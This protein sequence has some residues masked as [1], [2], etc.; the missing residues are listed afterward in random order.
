[1]TGETM[2]D[3]VKRIVVLGST[4][5]VG[6]QTL[7]VV[8]SL[9]ERFCVVGLSGH[10]RCKLLA[11]QVKE[12]RPDIVA[13][14]DPDGVDS[15]CGAVDGVQVVC[16]AE[17]LTRLAAWEDADIIVCAV[18]GVAGVP[19]TV[20][21][22]RSGKVLALANKESVVMCGDYLNKLARENGGAIL[23]VDSE[24]SAVFQLLQGLPRDSV[25]RV[26]ITAS[27]GPFYDR[28]PAELEAVTPEEAV[29]HPNWNM[30]R[31]ISVDSATM[32]NKAL[33]VVEARWLFDLAPDRIDVLIHPQS[34]VHGIVELVDG[35]SLAHMGVPDMRIPIHYA[36][37]YPK[38]AA[39]G[40][41]RL[42]LTEAG[43]LEFFA[44]DPEQFPALELGFRVAR[45]G[46]TSG[47]VLNAADEAAVAAFMDGRISFT[48]I[49]PVVR[50]VLDRHEVRRAPTL[51]AAMDA[52]RWAREEAER[53]LAAL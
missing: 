30:G 37:S 50:Q 10:S 32:M 7:D 41:G 26:C 18:S 51:E 48:Q 35:S 19:A 38:R 36:L 9:P 42:D 28:S 29:S 12:F 25:R 16:G 5:S 43:R 24:H 21:A 46:G 40:A 49:V 31:K 14:T 6:T 11:E 3:E 2:A 15:L 8:R 52:D 1:M 17:G 27:G 39:G 20:A 23:P 45:T 53:C 22:L 44:P 4:G 33:E 34:I 47:A 13:M